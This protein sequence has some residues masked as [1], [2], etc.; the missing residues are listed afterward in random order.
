[1]KNLIIQYYDQKLP[2][3]GQISRKM[4]EQYAAKHGAEYEYYD[5][6]ELGASRKGP[7]TAP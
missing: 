1:M 3:W 4:F 2:K 5:K 6:L 7:G